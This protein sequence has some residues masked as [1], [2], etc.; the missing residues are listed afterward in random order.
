MWNTN[1]LAAA[2]VVRFVK[3]YK[4]LAL[5]VLLG[6]RDRRS[7][8]RFQSVLYQ[9]DDDYDFC[10]EQEELGTGKRKTS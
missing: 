2:H 5:D 6:C 8:L 1:L 7:N 9:Q 10:D 3:L 4:D